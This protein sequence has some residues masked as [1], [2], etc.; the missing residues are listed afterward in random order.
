MERYIYKL[1]LIFLLLLAYAF[2]SQRQYEV[3]TA[4]YW[5]SPVLVSEYWILKTDKLL[6]AEQ[7]IIATDKAF[8]PVLRIHNEGY[9]YALSAI[10]DGAKIVSLVLLYNYL[11]TS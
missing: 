7:I 11:F 4:G 2:F 1:G 10:V 3:R 9:E 5:P 6:V 8:R